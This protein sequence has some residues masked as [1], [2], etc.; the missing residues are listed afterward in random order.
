MYYLAAKDDSNVSKEPDLE[1]QPM[2]GKENECPLCQRLFRSRQALTDH[3]RFSHSVNSE[4]VVRLQSL[5]KGYDLLSEDQKRNIT[6]EHKDFYQ[7]STDSSGIGA[8]NN[9]LNKL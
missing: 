4:G 7:I 3:A 6:Q 8:T 5:I 2:P 9:I 1:M